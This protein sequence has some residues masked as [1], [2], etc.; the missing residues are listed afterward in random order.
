MRTI[1]IEGEVIFGEVYKL[2]NS[3]DNYVYISSTILPLT[4]RL[5]DHRYSYNQNINTELCNHLRRI[6][7]DKRTIKLLES[8]VVEN[9]SELRSMEQKWIE[10]ENP[11]YLLNFENATYEDKS[12]N[13]IKQLIDSFHLNSDK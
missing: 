3:K 1:N 11:K 2:Y 8:R 9:I 6:G 13:V 5:G 10:E 12:L 4:K 7:L